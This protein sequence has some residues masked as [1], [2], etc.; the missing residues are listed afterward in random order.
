MAVIIENLD[1][2]IAVYTGS[3][4]MKTSQAPLFLLLLAGK[5]T[6]QDAYLQQRAWKQRQGHSRFEQSPG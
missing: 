5:Q 3:R 6:H 1:S 4:I 2:C